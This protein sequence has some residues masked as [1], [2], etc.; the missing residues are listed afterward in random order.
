[1]HFAGSLFLSYPV[2][3]VSRYLE[4]YSQ[5][6]KPY[7]IYTFWILFE[8]LLRKKNLEDKHPIPGKLCYHGMCLTVH[9]GGLNGV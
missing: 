8:G 5:N 6:F 3:S 4:N 9:D 1:M 2:A 7:K